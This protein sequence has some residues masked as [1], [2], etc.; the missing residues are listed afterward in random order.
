MGQIQGPFDTGGTLGSHSGGC[1]IIHTTLPRLWQTTTPTLLSE[2][3]PLPLP[4]TAGPS[5]QLTFFCKIN[6]QER[7]KKRATME[8]NKTKRNNFDMGAQHLHLSPG[9]PGW[10]RARKPLSTG[11][12]APRFRRGRKRNLPFRTEAHRPDV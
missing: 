10:G 12:F 5:E 7:G 9:G 3:S 11:I 2:L 8:R 6:H 1:P 4:A